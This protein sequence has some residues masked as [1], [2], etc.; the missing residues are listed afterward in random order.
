MA[1]DVYD[2]AGWCAIFLL[3]S[4]VVCDEPKSLYDESDDIVTLQSHNLAKLIHNSETAWFVEFY[5]SWC[6]H[7]I[8][9]AP[10]WKQLG[11]DIKGRV[12]NL[13]TFILIYMYF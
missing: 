13:A 12:P 1:A 4:C 6:G 9:F 7:C 2:L 10:V 5:N 11:T 3:F 8:R